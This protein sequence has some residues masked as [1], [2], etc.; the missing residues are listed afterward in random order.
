M[1]CNREE[2]TSWTKTRLP[3]WGRPR[4]GGEAGVKAEKDGSAG[5]AWSG[6]RDSGGLLGGLPPTPAPASLVLLDQ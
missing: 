4:V 6:S 3:G 2:G 1:A 5:W